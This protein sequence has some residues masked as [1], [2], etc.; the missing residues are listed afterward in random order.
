MLLSATKDRLHVVAVWIEYER[1]EVMW[2]ALAG[3]PNVCSTCF[4]RSG[5]EGIHLRLIPRDECRMLANRVRVEAIDPEDRILDAVADTVCA[6]I[7]RQLHNAAQTQYAQRGVVE[8]SRPGHV[9][10]ANPGVLNHCTS[11]WGEP[12]GQRSLGNMVA[13]GSAYDYP[14]LVWSAKRTI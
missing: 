7:L 13:Q 2:P 12:R 14:L 6:N 8:L 10:N 4:Q 1:S 11:P 5:V 9:S 3:C